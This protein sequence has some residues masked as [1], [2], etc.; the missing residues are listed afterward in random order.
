MKLLV[1]E[2]NAKLADFLSRA[3]TEEGFS[4]DVVADGNVAL[5]QAMA[6]P[7]DLVVLDWMLPGVDGL[8]VCRTLRARG[9]KTP[10]LMLTARAGTAERVA[11][12][13]AG[14]D[15]FVPKPF[16][17]DELFARTRALLRRAGPDAAAVSVGPFIVDRDNRCVRIDEQRIDLTPRE[18]ALISYLA[19]N[20]GRVVS[21]ME[22]LSRV[23]NAAYDTGS[24]VVEVHIKNLRDKL[25]SHA[26]MIE[27]VRGVGYRLA[28]AAPQPP[29]PAS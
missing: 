4:V 14:A 2:D 3:Y 13:D 29:P 9:K 1:V 22:L 25:G 7:Y 23:W 16:E 12:L 28:T 8:T 20:A 10:I 6:V 15:D 5:T 21:K 27:T 18:F 19:R 17:L 11:G 24:N 26:T